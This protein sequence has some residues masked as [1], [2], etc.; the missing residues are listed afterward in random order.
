MRRRLLPALFVPVALALGLLLARL[1]PPFQNPDEFAHLL[2]AEQVSRGI[3]LGQRVD[4]AAAPD[5]GLCRL[6]DDVAF[7]VVPGRATTGGMVDAGL[8]ELA[9]VYRDLPFQRDRKATPAMADAA[10]RIGW[11]GRLHPAAFTNTAVYPPLLY[12]PAAATLGTARMAGMPPPSAFRLARAVN[13]LIAIG[14]AALA[15]HLCGRGRASMAVLLVLPMT[16]ALGGSIAP[17]GMLIAGAALGA[18]ILSRAMQREAGL[19]WGAILGFGA[20]VLALAL[21]RPPYLLLGLLALAAPA[22]TPLGPAGSW[23]SRLL[24]LAV[25]LPA[26]LAA[27]GWMATAA[28]VMVPVQLPEVQPD[29]TAQARFLLE[30]PLRLPEILARTAAVS[31]ASILRQAIGVLGWLDTPLPGLVYL[32]AIMALV[33]ALAADGGG[34]DGRPGPEGRAVLL[35]AVVL[36]GTVTAIALA[37]YLSYSPVG[38]P[39]VQGIQGRYLL[40]LLLLALPFLPRLVPPRPWSGP[41]AGLGIVA[42]I[43]CVGLL[44]PARLITRY[45]WP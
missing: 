19:S 13:L 27:L 31:G 23:P 5:P 12:L 28:P 42:L 41:A 37:L 21:A 34:L 32:A 2:R 3:W 36:A 38:H 33:L 44:V 45:G 43:L 25:L 15:L 16:L 7:G 10:M 11:T 40:P 18:S 14:L 1:T 9:A 24:R 39:V 22:A 26:G 35:A 30:H 8:L 17:D 20:V 29:L 4:C 6:S